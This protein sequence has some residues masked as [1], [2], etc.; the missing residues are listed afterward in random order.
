MKN[1]KVFL[2]L[3]IIFI[4]GLTP[5]LWFR[6]DEVILGHDAGLT[7]SPVSH[8][9]DRLY[10]WTERFGF[11]N[12]QTYAIPGFFIHGLEAF[13]SYLGFSL[14][15]QQK[16]TFIFWFVIP[17]LTMYYFA[18][19]LANKYNLPYF[20]FPV[21]VM[22]MLNHY[23]LQGWFIAERTKFSVYAAAPLLLAFLFDWKEKEITSLR[24]GVLIALTFFFL[25]GLASPPLFGGIIVLILSFIIFYLIN[26]SQRNKLISLITLLTVTS[27]F[28]ILLQAYWLLPYGNHVKGSYSTAVNFYGGV[29]GI[30]DW[31]KYISEHSSYGNLFRLQGI[32][33]WY[34]N[35]FH[36]YSGVFL[37]NNLLVFVSFLLPVAAFISFDLYKNNKIRKIVLFF[38]IVALISFIFVAGAHPPFGAFYLFL[39]QYIPGFIA[40]RTPFYKFAYSLWLSYAVLIGFTINY[41][42][43]KIRKR[44]RLLSYTIFILIIISIFIYNFPFFTGVFFDYIKNT[45]SMRISV[46]QYVLDYGS[47]SESPERITKKTL[48]LPAVNPD[49]NVEAYTWGYWSL[50]PVSSLLTNAPLINRNI[51]M[52]KAE[53]QI[54]TD[55]YR[56]IKENDPTWVRV[57]GALGIESVLL[58]KDFAWYL[59]DSPTDNPQVYMKALSVPEVHLSKTFGKWEVYDIKGKQLSQISGNSSINFVNKYPE[60]TVD[61]FTLPAY[62][63]GS[64]LAFSS[65]NQINMNLLQKN[66]SGM[67]L[68]ADCVMCNLQWKFIN[69]DEYIPLLT[70]GS[71]FYKLIE[72]AELKNESL[73]NKDGK[74]SV[75]YYAYQALRQFMSIQKQLNENEKISFIKETGADAERALSKFRDKYSIYIKKN[76]YQDTDFQ[77]ENL[78]IFRLMKVTISEVNDSIP[79]HSNGSNRKELF[80]ISESLNKLILQNVSVLEKTTWRTRN[81]TDKSFLVNAPE[82]G[83][84]AL[85][86]KANNELIEP[87]IRFIVN[88]QQFQKDTL[89]EVQTWINMGTVPLQKGD[90][91]ITVIQPSVNLVENTQEIVLADQPAGCY[92]SGKFPSERNNLYKITFKHQLVKGD[93]TKFFFSVLPASKSL[94]SSDQIDVLTAYSETRTY[95]NQY[96]SGVENGFY[97]KICNR[98]DVSDGGITSHVIVQDISVN[99]VAVPE[100]ILYKEKN[101]NNKSVDLSFLRHN[102]T[103]YVLSADSNNFIQLNESF[104]N[105]WVL[106]NC[107]GVKLLTNG[108]LN[109]WFITNGVNECTIEYNPQKI[110]IFGFVVSGIT[111]VSCIYIL[112]KQYGKK[113]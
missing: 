111:L 45:R 44:N 83:D 28:S 106:N 69:R 58:R 81:I 80:K 86:Y 52:T 23:L 30:L 31:I 74:E 57:A 87:K 72:N 112:I 12:D 88:G 56:L 15:G 89:N 24:A 3:L 40:F 21:S 37:S 32:P 38:G 6:G 42:L 20:A 113:V 66:V 16:I 1:K 70:R 107:V 39:V 51:Y 46:P 90:N 43:L 48:V 9:I 67:Y 41:M 26:K 34:Q 98:Q 93:Y 19:R 85:Y 60:K 33:E 55:L 95:E 64:I 54:L 2:E 25:N 71:V 108:Y 91:K 97:F 101:V 99:K 47:W 92:T 76:P 109:G 65:Q 35:P 96:L 8:F 110:L 7:L 17:G 103:K 75:L 78:S 5:L 94:I 11:G 84:F 49:S 10:T 13:I 4:L 63:P 79:R 14:Q 61:I 82:N 77:V 68:F 105:D 27:F 36:P 18:S 73:V 59:K 22:Y 50:A 53:Q 104:S 29:N 62:V 102:Q 100:L